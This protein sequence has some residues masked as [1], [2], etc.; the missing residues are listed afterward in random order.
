ML[1]HRRYFTFVGIDLDLSRQCRSDQKLRLLLV[2][3]GTYKQLEDVGFA[4]GHANETSAWQSPLRLRGGFVSD[5]PLAAFL[6]V[7]RKSLA[8]FAGPM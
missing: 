2:L 5:H 8:L 7:N 6:L 4:V 3:S 1:P